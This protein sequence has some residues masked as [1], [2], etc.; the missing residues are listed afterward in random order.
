[1][2]NVEALTH[3]AKPKPCPCC[4]CNLGSNDGCKSGLGHLDLAGEAQ[5]HAEWYLNGCPN[6]PRLREP[7]PFEIE[8]FDKRECSRSEAWRCIEIENPAKSNRWQKCHTARTWC[9]VRQ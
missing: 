4:A 1:M 6:N 7:Q 5:A 2:P 3:A 8:W 9:W